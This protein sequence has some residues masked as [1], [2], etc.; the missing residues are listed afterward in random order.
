[1]TAV[2]QALAL[3][4]VVG[5]IFAAF[6]QPVPA[7]ATIAGVAGVVGLFV[8]WSGVAALMSRGG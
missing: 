1:M 8:G 2:V 7:P 3:G 6:R 4:I 5:A